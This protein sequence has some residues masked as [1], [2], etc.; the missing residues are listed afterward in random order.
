MPFEVPVAFA[1]HPLIGKGC[2]HFAE[3]QV[4]GLLVVRF[5]QQATLSMSP[6]DQLDSWLAN[7]PTR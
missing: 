4:I 3:E 5:G 7:R 1:E 2:D 6:M